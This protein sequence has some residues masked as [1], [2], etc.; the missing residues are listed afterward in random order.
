MTVQVGQGYSAAKSEFD[1]ESLQ[2]F[3]GLAEEFVRDSLREAGV[4]A[5]ISAVID[6]DVSNAIL[7]A[8]VDYDLIIIGASNEWGFRQWLFGSLPD[9]V[10]NNASASVLMVRSR[11]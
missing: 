8:S 1:H 7:K 9:K 6:T 4:T 10:A 3:Q 11:A 2:F 5:E